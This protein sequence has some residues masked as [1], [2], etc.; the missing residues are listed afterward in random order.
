ML[1]KRQKEILASYTGV[2]EPHE[3]IITIGKWRRFTREL[4]GG[5][6]YPITIKIVYLID[7]EEDLSQ[8]IATCTYPYTAIEKGQEIGRYLCDTLG[9]SRDVVKLRQK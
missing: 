1:G 2:R 7:M 4:G 9:L 6:G 5:S 8:W 3:I